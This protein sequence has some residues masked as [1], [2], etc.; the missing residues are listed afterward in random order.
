MDAWGEETIPSSASSKQSS[1]L[2]FL[3]IPV[4][5]TGAFY[6]QLNQDIGLLRQHVDMKLRNMMESGQTDLTM[7][8]AALRE[9]QGDTSRKSRDYG[10]ISQA[11][12]TITEPAANLSHSRQGGEAYRHEDYSEVQ[13]IGVVKNSPLLA[14]QEEMEESREEYGSR[15]T[16]G[17]LMMSE[18]LLHLGEQR[19]VPR[20]FV[21][22]G[23]EQNIN[24]P[25]KCDPSEEE[26]L[27]ELISL[28]DYE[29]TG[30]YVHQTMPLSNVDSTRRADDSS[31]AEN[32]ESSG[33]ALSTSAVRSAL[34]TVPESRAV[35]DMKPNDLKLRS[36]SALSNFLHQ[37]SSRQSR[38]AQD[39]G[40]SISADGSEDQGHATGDIS[41]EDEI[42]GASSFSEDDNV[43]RARKDPDGIGG[44]RR[45]PKLSPKLL[46]DQGDQTKATN[47]AEK[48]ASSLRSKMQDLLLATNPSNQTPQEVSLEDD[49]GDEA[50]R[51]PPSSALT[52]GTDQED[53][54]RLGEQDSKKKLPRK[55]PTPEAT[56][57]RRSASASS[58]SKASVASSKN[59][60]KSE[61]SGDSKKMR[62]P[63]VKPSPEA[64][65]DRSSESRTSQNN[66]QLKES[67]ALADS[68]TTASP[69]VK[70]DETEEERKN[71]ETDS[72][73][74][75]SQDVQPTHET[76]DNA[77]K[78]SKDHDYDHVEED[79]DQ[80]APP[81]RE[82]VIDPDDQSEQT[83]LDMDGASHHKERTRRKN[84]EKADKAQTTKDIPQNINFSESQSNTPGKTRNEDKRNERARALMKYNASPNSGKPSEAKSVPVVE[85]NRLV[86]LQ[87]VQ[88]KIIRDP[89]GDEGRY[90]GVMVSGKPHGQ[91]TMNYRDGRLYSGE[92]RQG[93]W[94][95]H[96]HA[97]FANGDSYIGQYENDQRHGHGR[98]EWADGRVYDG[99]FKF[100]HRQGS[101]SYTW[102][103]GAVYT[104][105]FAK[106][107]RHGKGRYIFADGSCY[108]GGW[109]EGK[110]HGQGE[111]VWSDGRK[112]SGNWYKG[113]AHGMGIEHRPDGSVRHEGEWRR[114]RPIR[115]KQET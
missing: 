58:P 9:M 24:L 113:M 95:G 16:A 98:Y 99:G 22:N 73:V 63:S 36:Q 72:G 5:E 49:D 27:V 115:P 75:H 60:A 21:S 42:S 108:M 64:P 31:T 90:T 47:E 25:A 89:Y 85:D 1:A 97:I 69:L 32:S 37:V 50:T 88:N 13:I 15:S 12:S 76:T 111:C 55:P 114:D 40:M 101:G 35:S 61:T 106:G 68:L 3:S 107:L 14:V 39:L 54:N 52:S 10:D 77:V 103:D 38:E 81:V 74:V 83:D 91:G 4:D 8:D 104:G 11:D 19:E 46:L 112:Y 59:S 17:R 45:I 70:A 28:D 78:Q 30:H 67:A 26:H 6:Q 84:Q 2:D 105:D 110:Y 20:G 65:R 33:A 18:N 57:G 102:P 93:R 34:Q 92:W 86:L 23:L 66:S 41:N 43:M 29:S 109:K 79:C 53:E 82:L 80:K 56:H 96:G 62:T 94:H 44:Q 71:E 100:D 7:M 51:K 87:Q 48:S